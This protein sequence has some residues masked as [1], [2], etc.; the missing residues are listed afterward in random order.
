MKAM[1]IA[2]EYYNLKDKEL[3]GDEVNIWTL[4]KRM[5]L[6]NVN[7]LYLHVHACY[8]FILMGMNLIYTEN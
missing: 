2:E 1:Q 3:S 4:W 6:N 5:V 7:E 8:A